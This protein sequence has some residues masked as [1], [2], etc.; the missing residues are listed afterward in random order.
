G[1]W[2]DDLGGERFHAEEV[3][4]VAVVQPVAD[5]QVAAYRQHEV[6]PAN[7]EHGAGVVDDGRTVDG[8]HDLAKL[9]GRGIAVVTLGLQVF[10]V[11]SRGQHDLVGAGDASGVEDLHGL[12]DVGDHLA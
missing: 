6:V 1:V 2:C 3:D 9:A 4:G 8:R 7:R 11:P 12:Q 5:A 10:E